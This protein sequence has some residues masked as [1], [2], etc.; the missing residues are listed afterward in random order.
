MI[1]GSGAVI[2]RRSVLG[3]TLLLG[4]CAAAPKLA[5]GTGAAPEVASKRV[6]FV[7]QFGSVK[8]PIARE[9]AKRRAA[10]RGLKIDFAA[11]GITPEEH[12]ASELARALVADRIN[13]KAEPLQPLTA[14]DVARADIVVAF[15]KLPAHLAAVDVRDWSSLPSMNKD[16]AAARADLM[17]RIDRLLDGLAS[18]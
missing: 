15:D 17:T 10:E 7:C 9:L 13:P 6:L 1:L 5:R 11:R 14:A 12:I 8:S 3:A 16:Y 2:G 18:G 4:A